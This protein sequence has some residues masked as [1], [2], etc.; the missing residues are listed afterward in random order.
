MYMTIKHRSYE[1]YSLPAVSAYRETLWHFSVEICTC[2]HVYALVC[3]CV[4]VCVHVCVCVCM[5]VHVCVCVCVQHLKDSP[6]YMVLVDSHYVSSG[7]PFHYLPQDHLELVQGER[8]RI[9]APEIDH[10][11]EGYKNNRHIPR[12]WLKKIYPED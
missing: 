7:S 2:L 4:C 8:V 5:C 10:Y 6:N 3:V 11:F 9:Q 1:L 12:P